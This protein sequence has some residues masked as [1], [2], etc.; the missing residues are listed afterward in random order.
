[1]KELGEEN[2]KKLFLI[3]EPGKYKN[4]PNGLDDN[5]HFS[6][7]GAEIIAGLVAKGIKE[8]EIDLKNYLKEKK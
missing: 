4:Y 6:D 8:L 7:Y 5:T 2:S 1:M 3:L